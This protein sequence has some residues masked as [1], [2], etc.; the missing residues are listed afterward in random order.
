MSINPEPEA[1]L[2]R[3]LRARRDELIKLLDASSSHWGYEDPVYR[4][5]HQSFK[6]FWL[7]EQTQAIVGAL[8]SLAPDRTLNSW[9][10]EIVNDGTGKV[11][12]L[13]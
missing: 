8:A 13:K 1:A 3:S 4:F 5:Y 9:F 7:Q 6:V 11:F 2:V 10:T 12:D